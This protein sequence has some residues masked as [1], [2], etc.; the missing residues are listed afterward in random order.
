VLLLNL[1]SVRTWGI[2]RH[3][4]VQLFQDPSLELGAIVPCHCCSST[5]MSLW[6]H[7]KR[8]HDGGPATL[9]RFLF[10]ERGC[11]VERTYYYLSCHSCFLV[12]YSNSPSPLGYHM[13]LVACARLFGFLVVYSYLLI[14]VSRLVLLDLLISLFWPIR[15]IKVYSICEFCEL[16]V[17]RQHAAE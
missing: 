16:S 14:P 17:S 5:S 10:P 13:I 9:E 3:T 12:P 2:G 11:A 15:T 1:A 6:V 7:V 4:V 8:Y